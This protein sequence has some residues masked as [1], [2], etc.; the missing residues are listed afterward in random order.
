MVLFSTY[1][2]RGLRLLRTRDPAA[3]QTIDWSG[4]DA[5]TLQ[6]FF[7]TLK[8]CGRFHP[9]SHVNITCATRVHDWRRLRH[10]EQ[11][12]IIDSPPVG[13]QY[14]PALLAEEVKVRACTYE[15]R[16]LTALKN[17]NPDTFENLDWTGVHPEILDYYFP[18]KKG[19]RFPP[20]H[21][22]ITSSQKVRRWRAY[23]S[24]QQE[25]IIANPPTPTIDIA[26]QRCDRKRKRDDKKLNSITEVCEVRDT[27]RFIM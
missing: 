2:I 22:D 7:P 8:D 24:K 9:P 25:D 10:A 13:S 3:F 16:G 20:P 27:G 12:A 23:S 26:A 18:S 17:R 19:N 14:S 4:A 15:K 21:F 6:K 5:E 1:T 11:K